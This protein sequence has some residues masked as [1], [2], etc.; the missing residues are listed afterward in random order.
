MLFGL[1]KSKAKKLRRKPKLWSGDSMNRASGWG[2]SIKFTDQV[3]RGVVRVK[4]GIVGWKTPKP[5]NGDYL[6][7]RMESGRVGVFKIENV[8]S[9]GDPHDM[10]FAD[11][12]EV[13]YKDEIELVWE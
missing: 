8:K 12:I 1:L 3:S 7:V 13:G 4:S 10:F 6:Q 2:N 11:V 5:K 9:C